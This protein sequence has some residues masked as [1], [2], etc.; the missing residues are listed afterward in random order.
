MKKLFE[1]GEL[2]GVKDTKTGKE[3]AKAWE[4]TDDMK[5]DLPEIYKIFKPYQFMLDDSGD[6]FI[7]HCCDDN[8][9]LDRERFKVVWNKE[10]ELFNGWCCIII[11]I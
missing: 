11:K 4:L 1:C 7:N 9:Y 2:F 10:H 8:A 5:D 3:Y 6:V